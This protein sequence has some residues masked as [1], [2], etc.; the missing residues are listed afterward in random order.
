MVSLQWITGARV[1]GAGCAVRI[2][3]IIMMRRGDVKKHGRRKMHTRKTDFF[4]NRDWTPH[5]K[6]RNA[7]R[8]AKQIM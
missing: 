5:G 2:Q 1:A 7:P 3:I 6:L 8:C 4:I